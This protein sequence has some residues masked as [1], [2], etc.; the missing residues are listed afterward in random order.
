M[1]QTPTDV[2][3]PFMAQ[4][5]SKKFDNGHQPLKLTNFATGNSYAG[6]PAPPTSGGQGARPTEL[7][8][9]SKELWRDV[10]SSR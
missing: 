5:F 1:N 7:S 3:A 6:L 8:N 2:G 9:S 10:G 4:V